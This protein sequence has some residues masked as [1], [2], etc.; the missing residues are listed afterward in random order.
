ML[1]AYR[2][3]SVC[4]VLATIGFF[5]GSAAPQSPTAA[6]MKRVTFPWDR[7]APAR[8]VQ[9]LEGATDVT[10]EGRDPV[11]A[12]VY[13][14]WTGKPFPAGDDWIRD[15]VFVVKNFSNKE[16]I[17]M[18]I[19]LDF[20]QTGAGVPGSP[21]VASGISLGREP[22]NALYDPRT[23]RKRAS[24]QQISDRAP[25]SILPNQEVRIAVAPH[26]DSIK[27]GIEA[28]QPISTITTC[29]VSFVVFYFADGTR[30]GGGFWKPDPNN[31]GMYLPMTRDEWN[32]TTPVRN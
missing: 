15:L 25:F 18:N 24:A 27:A 7:N 3:G 16:V 8:I 17:A 6:D 13:K 21:M 30:F 22:E 14:P 4:F 5:C 11:T 2:K 23:G 9:V 29:R 26:Y 10:G 12:Q 28:K 1:K 19:S 32:A 31:P 20:P